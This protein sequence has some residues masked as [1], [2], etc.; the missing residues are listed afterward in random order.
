[1]NDDPTDEDL[2]AYNDPE[3]YYAPPIFDQHMKEYRR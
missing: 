2:L 3:G 1:M